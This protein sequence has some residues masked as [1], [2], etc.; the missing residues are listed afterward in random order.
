[1]NENRIGNGKWVRLRYAQKLIL[2]DGHEVCGQSRTVSFVFG[3]ERQMASIEKALDGRR[4]G[5]RLT[6]DIPAEE[7]FG[8][9]DPDLERVIPRGGLKKARLKEGS[10]Y[11]EIKQGAVVSFVVKNLYENSVLADFNHPYAGAG[12]RGE[13]DILEVRDADKNDIR[14]AHD[15]MGCG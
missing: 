14:E 5:D 12:A 6:V 15:R 8:A 11:R 1:M 7:L 3:I 13:I 4:A 9:H 2:R 10:V